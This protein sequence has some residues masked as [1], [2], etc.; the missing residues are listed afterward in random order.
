MYMAFKTVYAHKD[1]FQLG[2]FIFDGKRK[3]EEE[4][5][6]LPSSQ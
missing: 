4:T 3:I 1:Q 5:V 2:Y 6:G